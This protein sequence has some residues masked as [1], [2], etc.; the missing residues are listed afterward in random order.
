MLFRD[1][2]EKICGLL[3]DAK[4]RAD[5]G[6]VH[7]GKAE[8][9]ERGLH[10]IRRCVRSE[11]ADEGRREHDIN[12]NAA[13]YRQYGLEYLAF[14][15]Y[16][17]EGA[18]YQALAA[19][20]ALFIV[21]RRTAELVLSDGRDAAGLFAGALLTDDRGEG[22]CIHASAA[23]DALFRVDMCVT[24]HLADGLFG[25]DLNAWMLDAALTAVGYLDDVIRAAVAGEFDD[26]YERR[27]VI[28][29]GNDRLLHAVGDIVVLT[30]LARRQTH[31]KAQPF[32][33]N[34]ALDQ[35][36]VPERAYLIGIAR[37]DLVRQLLDPLGIVSALVR[38]ACDLRE[39]HV[40]YTCFAGLHSSHWVNPPNVSVVIL[41]Q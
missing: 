12:G 16:R 29:L 27:L 1:L 26:V 31:S 23:A 28:F 7:I 25:A 13:F 4:I 36:I 32:A 11:L 21:Y 20:G 33:D 39:N 14:I 34:G 17:A 9:P 3:D 10:L 19:G 8:T 35:K 22:A 6:L 30:E 37:T 5:G 2:L 15:A 18:V 24:A 40:P 41:K 38:H